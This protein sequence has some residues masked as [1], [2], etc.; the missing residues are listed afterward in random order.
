MRKRLRVGLLAIGLLL[1]L[2]ASGTLLWARYTTRWR[3][4][5]L[6]PIAREL[7]RRGVAQDTSGLRAL[8]S[9][10]APVQWSLGFGR[11][12]PAWARESAHSLRLS[13]AAL[14]A[15]DTAVAFFR[16]AAPICTARYAGEV[17][18]FQFTYVRQGERWVVIRAGMT[19]C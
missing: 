10:S 18:E 6:T 4:E 2:A 7:L 14:T 19:P 13:M 9:D 8:A 5:A 16:T 1:L 12:E 11:E 15:P 3:W 17:N